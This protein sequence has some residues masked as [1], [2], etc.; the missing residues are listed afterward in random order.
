MK[1]FNN[2]SPFDNKKSHAQLKNLMHQKKVLDIR[3]DETSIIWIASTKVTRLP[4]KVNLS[5]WNW[6]M[7]YLKNGDYEDICINDEV[8]DFGDDFQLDRLKEL[9]EKGEQIA[10][11]PFIRDTQAFVK[12]V[13]LFAH[14]K[15]F[16]SIR[17]TPEL[18][19]YLDRKDL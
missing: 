11:V 7:N 8:T 12:L 3:L 9:I 4:Y 1:F 18:Q 15:I 13:G 17:N 5:S 2:V 6:I 14:G 16:F 19:D 10:R